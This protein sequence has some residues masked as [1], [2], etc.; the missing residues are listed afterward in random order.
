MWVS[1]RIALYQ[2][3]VGSIAAVIWWLTAGAAQAVAAFAGGATG[4]ILSF[5]AG[6]RT[7][8]RRSEDPRVLLM[9]FYRAQAWKF[10]L[11][12]GL[13]IL[14][15]KLFGHDFLPYITAYAATATV[16]WFSLLWKK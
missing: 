4:A 11:A 10:V 3:A 7:F 8:G 9:S 12:C 13:F 1:T 2:I 16:Y 14:A 6:I 5:Y 15:I